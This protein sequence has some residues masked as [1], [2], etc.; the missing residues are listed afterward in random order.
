LNSGSIPSL[1]SSDADIVSPG[2]I[3]GID[4]NTQNDT[5]ALMP[6]AVVT[7][8]EVAPED[9]PPA[10]LTVAVAELEFTMF[11]FVTVPAPVPM[12]TVIGA[13]NRAPVNVTGTALPAAPNDGLIVATAGSTLIEI[14]YA[15]VA[16]TELDD[17]AM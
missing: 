12:L 5:G 6:V 14:A 13:P 7:V 2:L 16:E 4:G 15:P 10:T 8:T 9:A 11:R 17:A 1:E 3:G